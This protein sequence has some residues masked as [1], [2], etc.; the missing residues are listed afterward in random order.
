[1]LGNTPKS[2]SYPAFEHAERDFGG[3]TFDRAIGE[4]L[5]NMIY[6]VINRI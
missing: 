3:E 1:M 5:V 4:L 6:R 2:I